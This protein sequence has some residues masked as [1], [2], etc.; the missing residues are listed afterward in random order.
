MPC[1]LAAT[2]ACARTCGLLSVMGWFSA[3]CA[4]TLA[5]ARKA[6]VMTVMCLNMGL[7]FRK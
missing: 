3:D 2:L 1:V 6:A 5:A 4:K 7:A